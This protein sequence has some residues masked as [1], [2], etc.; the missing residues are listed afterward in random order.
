MANQH[1]KPYSAKNQPFLRRPTTQTHQ[2]EFSITSS[3]SRNIHVRSH[4]ATNSSNSNNI[5]NKINKD[6][7]RNLVG[8]HSG[9]A[10]PF[11]AATAS[12]NTT[13][14]GRTGV[15]H[16]VPVPAPARQFT[17]I[18]GGVFNR[19]LSADT[20]TPVSPAPP[21]HHVPANTVVGQAQT[22]PKPLTIQL[23]RESHQITAPLDNTTVTAPKIS[24]P[25]F[26]VP[27]VP[28]LEIQQEQSFSLRTLSTLSPNLGRPVT[29]VSSVPELAPKPNGAEVNIAGQIVEPASHRPHELTDTET[30]QYTSVEF[31]ECVVDEIA[32]TT[33]DYM[34]KQEE[35]S[36][37]MPRRSISSSSVMPPPV[38]STLDMSRD[39]HH[40]DLPSSATRAVPS[41][42]L[43][44]GSVDLTD[45]SLMLMDRAVIK[46]RWI[47]A[48]R[49]RFR[50]VDELRTRVKEETDNYQSAWQAVNVLT[51]SNSALQ[52]R[53]SHLQTDVARLEAQVAES[54]AQLQDIDTDRKNQAEVHEAFRGQ[55]VAHVDSIKRDSMKAST[56]FKV[57]VTDK[58]RWEADLATLRASVQ[59]MECNRDL[60]RM[61]HANLVASFSACSSQLKT[62][63][64]DHDRVQEISRSQKEDI[65]QYRTRYQSLSDQLHQQLEKV[66]VLNREIEEGRI[67]TEA[68]LVTN[69]SLSDRNGFLERA[70][71]YQLSI[72]T[73]Q[74]RDVEER[75]REAYVKELNKARDEFAETKARAVK[76][77]VVLE[78][79]IRDGTMKAEILA[80][81]NLHL[82]AELSAVKEDSTRYMDS[83]TILQ[84][85][86]GK[87][88]G[89][90]QRLIQS[91]MDAQVDYALEINDAKERFEEL[92]QRESDENQATI[93]IKDVHIGEL[94]RQLEEQTGEKQR[95][96]R[97]MLE[98]RVKIQLLQTDNDYLNKSRDDSMNELEVLQAHQGQQQ[99]PMPLIDIA[100]FHNRDREGGS[101][102][103]TDFLQWP[104][105]LGTPPNPRSSRLAGFHDHTYNRTGDEPEQ[106]SIQSYYHNDRNNLTILNSDARCSG[107]SD[108]QNQI[109]KQLRG[110]KT[111]S[112]SGGVSE[113]ND[114]DDELD[115][116]GPRASTSGGTGTG[117]IGKTRRQYTRRQ[118]QQQQ[119]S[120]TQPGSSS[121]SNTTATAVTVATKKTP[122]GK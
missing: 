65:D 104:T 38:A 122:R 117:T 109:L 51:V 30:V 116:P 102:S 63:Q 118:A 75:C 69:S 50:L 58:A 108:S 4:S 84:E 19:P 91:S 120:L 62:I 29:T 49:Q 13:S 20:K 15:S 39:H 26:P 40:E 36:P 97:D 31:D 35:E 61:S 98:L 106:Q 64:A 33:Q 5:N 7:N 41:H 103:V 44:K 3:T 110:R 114:Q 28:V 112:S 42:T 21:E 80:T 67:A 37:S 94:S 121:S 2:L 90:N 88:E 79:D 54:Q 113:I 100:N 23:P 1:L 60:L 66:G 25:F 45:I 8:R 95:L 82:E 78:S 6:D 73:S 77:I 56:A 18:K 86:K 55:M 16:S 107:G 10:F 76:E 70:C 34:P 12:T 92:R 48:E 74:L 115:A 43:Q 57:H 27:N 22:P 111:D 46:Q 119:Q 96:D 93:Q 17:M 53:N 47:E 105:G 59:D 99:Q 52:T 68:L 89:E 14:A 32:N 9:S 101:S 81:R 87:L 72:M 83:I 24:V 85:A 71:D 11:H